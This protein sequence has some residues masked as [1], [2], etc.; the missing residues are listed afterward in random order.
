MPVGNVVVTDSVASFTDNAVPFGSVTQNLTATQTITVTNDGNASLTLGQV[1][2]LN[3]LVAPFSVINDT[4]S[5]QVLAP[6]D[7]CTFDVR[8][9]PTAVGAASDALDIPSDDPDLAS[10]VVSVSG[11]GELAPAGGGGSSAFDPTTLLALGLFGFAGRRR[12]VA[13]PP[14]PG[15][16][17]SWS[18]PWRCPPA[19]PARCWR[20]HRAQ[21]PACR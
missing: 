2:T 19:P 18:R 14:G 15:R 13:G 11:T 9:Q 4:C 20:R 12:S 7:G 10:V 21:S 8:F 5:N 17:W 1:A 3:P 6:L 16:A